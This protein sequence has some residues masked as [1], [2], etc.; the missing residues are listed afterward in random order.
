MRG[1]WAVLTFFFFQ[2]LLCTFFL[3]KPNPVLLFIPLSRVYR[4][5][6]KFS[7]LKYGRSLGAC[8]LFRLGTGNSGGGVGVYVGR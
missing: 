1:P 4:E 7:S 2:F 8:E 6:A 5:Y 3:P